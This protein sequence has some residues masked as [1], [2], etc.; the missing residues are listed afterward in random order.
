MVKKN[1]YLVIKFLAATAITMLTLTSEAQP[2]NTPVPQKIRQFLQS[3]NPTNSLV[4]FDWDGTLYNEKIPTTT[5][6]HHPVILGGQAGWIMWSANR[7]FHCSQP[8]CSSRSWFPSFEQYDSDGK[9]DYK[10][11]AMSL[12][13]R[14]LFLE[15][16]YSEIQKTLPQNITS[17]PI[18]FS[19]YDKY[20]QA[21]GMASG[22]SLYTLSQSVQ[23]YLKGS[24]QQFTS[25]LN[26]VRAAERRHFKVWIITGSNPYYVANVIY[27]IDEKLP[28]KKR[29]LRSCF[30]L[31]QKVLHNK[32]TQLR[33]AAFFTQCPIAGNASTWSGGSGPFSNQYDDRNVTN[34]TQFK[35]DCAKLSPNNI[36][37]MA[38][39]GLGK[40]YALQ[41]IEHSEGKSIV[42]YAG[43]SDGD[44]Y[45]MQHVLHHGGFG[46]FVNPNYGDTKG[47]LMKM[48]LRCKYKKCYAFSTQQPKK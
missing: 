26:V 4:A 47:A 20:M 42:L 39:D 12:A 27:H 33:P 40:E 23:A 25:I 43:N 45:I 28:A 18:T 14:D 36:C 19:V 5:P 30:K 31:M 17:Q 22:M 11:W 37:K 34:G 46:V 9:I 41:H 1:T 3:Q 38:V 10:K 32:A 7:I 35:H 24:H 6:L 29:V 16:R 21:A 2:K 48:Y 15:G 44:V 13:E 8:A